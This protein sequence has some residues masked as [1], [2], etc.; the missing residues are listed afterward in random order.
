MFCKKCGKEIAEG[1]TT[2]PNAMQ[3]HRLHSCLR[4]MLQVE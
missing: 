4:R 2:C 1:L 3:Q